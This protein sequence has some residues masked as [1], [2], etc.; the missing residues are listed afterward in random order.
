MPASKSGPLYALPAPELDSVPGDGLWT[1]VS[2]GPA[3]ASL[4][5]AVPAPPLIAS[6]AVV[7]SD[8]FGALVGADGMLKTV[9]VMPSDVMIVSIA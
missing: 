7:V 1:E 8:G 9:W 2:P 6:V 5:N 4:L 3:G